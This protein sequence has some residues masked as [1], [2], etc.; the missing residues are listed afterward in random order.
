MT[1]KKGKE[2]V[3]KEV[4]E[5]PKVEAKAEGVV[6]R[7]EGEMEAGEIESGADVANT[8]DAVA[9][10]AMDLGV[11]DG[12]LQVKDNDFDKE[13]E[14]G[15]L[16]KNDVHM[17]QGDQDAVNVVQVYESMVSKCQQEF[18]T[19]A[20]LA[21]KEDVESVGIRIAQVGRKLV[22]DDG[23]EREVMKQGLRRCMEGILRAALE[24]QGNNNKDGM[25]Q[26]KNSLDR[27]FAVLEAARIMIAIRFGKDKDAS[28]LGDAM[29]ALDIIGSICVAG[30]LSE[31]VERVGELSDK[32][33]KITEAFGK[34]EL[35][36]L[37]LM[38]VMKRLLKRGSRITDPT[39]FGT[40]ITMLSAGSHIWHRSGVNFKG[41]CHVDLK[42]PTV[43]EIKKENADPTDWSLYKY[44]W[45]MH[46][47]I[48]DVPKSTSENGFKDAAKALETVLGAFESNTPTQNKEIGLS[49]TEGFGYF[50]SDPKLI[51]MQLSNRFFREHVLTQIIIWLHHV[52]RK[53][54][55]FESQI[56]ELRTRAWSLVG[57]RYARVITCAL[58]GEDFWASWKDHNCPNLK[59]Q[60]Y[61][62]PEAMQPV[63]IG[64]KRRMRSSGV[65]EVDADQERS[66]KQRVLMSQEP[67]EN[68]W[69]NKSPEE[70]RKELECTEEQLLSI[71]KIIERLNDDAD[72]TDEMDKVKNS[73]PF[74]WKSLRRLVRD[75]LRL[76][77]NVVNAN[78]DLDELLQDRSIAPLVTDQVDTP[79]QKV[80]VV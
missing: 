24:N 34:S 68:K 69:R 38:R 66:R 52:G 64:K 76:F 77:T 73:K 55:Q 13:L 74:V 53:L 25:L 80:S 47:C 46:N 71:D 31:L 22:V 60:N 17:V 50:L 20:D 45:T 23:M 6:E 40:I 54:P 1:K 32:V 65:T 37:H 7:E 51:R 57:E 72:K 39:F 11:D 15:E 26:G 58:E 75:D 29:F 27:A 3:K 70:R 78:L 43:D 61:V 63:I 18:L 33:L 44:F 49:L 2:D 5:E 9:Q 14:D 21:G 42:H 28:S 35:P 62:V 59:L 79:N 8:Q 10:V 67:I 36:K 19:A 48:V 12:D 56:N 30:P 4:K 16:M 41:N